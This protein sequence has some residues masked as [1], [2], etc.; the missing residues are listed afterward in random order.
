[1]PMFAHCGLLRR[2]VGRRRGI[3]IP[4]FLHVMFVVELVPDT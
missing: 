3:A 2:D 1:M 4:K